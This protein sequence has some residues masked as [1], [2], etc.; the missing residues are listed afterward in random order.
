LTAR[1]VRLAHSE[2][3][4]AQ[5]LAKSTGLEP[6]VVWVSMGLDLETDIISVEI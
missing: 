4:L 6:E 2:N 1:A 5:T 3:G